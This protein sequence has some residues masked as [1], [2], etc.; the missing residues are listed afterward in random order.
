MIGL[1]DSLGVAQAHIIGHSMGGMICQLLALN[2]PRR[3]RSLTLIST[4][5]GPNV[6]KEKAPVKEAL[7]ILFSI[8]V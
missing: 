3:C 1:L 8:C 6:G 5:A 7:H 4:T 2:F